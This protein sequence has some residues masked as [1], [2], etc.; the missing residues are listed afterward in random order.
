MALGQGIARTEV[1]VSDQS[2]LPSFADKG[3][4]AV[5]GIAE[6]G[7]M[8]TP[9]IVR[10]WAEYLRLYGGLV[11][12]SLNPLYCKRYLDA[13]GV[14]LFSRMQHYDD[15]SDLTTGANTNADGIHTFTG[16]AGTAE[17]EAENS[18]SWANGYYCQLVRAISGDTSKIDIIIRDPQQ[19]IIVSV[20]DLNQVPTNA[21]KNKF[22]GA[23][24]LVKLKSFSGSWADVNDPLIG[25]GS[26]QLSG[27]SEDYSTVSLGSYQGDS[28]VGTGIQAFDGTAIANKICI[29]EDACGEPDLLEIAMLD[30]VMERKDMISVFP[31]PL[32]ITDPED[33]YTYRMRESPYTG[34]IPN[35]Y[36]GF[37]VYGVLKVKNPLD[38]GDLNLHAIADVAACMSVREQKGNPWDAFGG[39]KNGRIY[40][41]SGLVF[42]VGSP[43]QRDLA[44]A[45]DN[46][47][48]NIVIDHPSFGTVAWGNSTLQRADTLLK[49]AN[50]AELLIHFIRRIP[51]LVDGF[52]FQPN[53]T[54]TW[55]NIYRAIA[56]EL[57]TYQA[58]RGIYGYIYTGDQDVDLVSQATYNTQLDIAAGIY[59]AKV[60][61]QPTPALKYIGVEIVVTNTSVIINPII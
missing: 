8:H 10:S 21:D 53:D 32:S 48:I 23:S 3:I 20:R 58:K 46:I 19:N 31:T 57:D 30:Y 24:Q 17:F 1:S 6:K 47:G 25:S 38:G 4:I 42:N 28:F 37:L 40:N 55:K 35:D 29:F 34:I 18:G 5:I 9:Q 61:I 52:L 27:G 13:G 16:V 2:L 33:I 60:E 56:Q 50:V 59:R 22:N 49:H 45:F 39:A 26:V 14:M 7:K 54:T 43:S 51:A 12:Y 44:D 36:R 11:S 15:P 41:N